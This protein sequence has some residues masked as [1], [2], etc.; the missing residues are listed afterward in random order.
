MRTL[1]EKTLALIALLAAGIVCCGQSA[2]ASR[3]ADIFR[4]NVDT[5]SPAVAPPWSLRPWFWEDDVN[6]SEAVWDLVNGCRDHDLPLGAILIDSPW[7]TAYNDFRFDE[8][9]YP[10]PR[11]M[12]NALHA[13]D[14][15][16]VLWMTNVVNTRDDRSDAPGTEED[17]YAIGKARG[18]LGGANGSGQRP[19]GSQPGI[20]APRR[21][22][23]NGS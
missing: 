17:L 6:T 14:I 12:I 15:R 19:G 13:R 4:S 18:Y 8:K 10:D 7:A 20:R 11:G 23:S 21:Y 5:S 16:V 1:Y 9:R 3:Q 2:D 22:H